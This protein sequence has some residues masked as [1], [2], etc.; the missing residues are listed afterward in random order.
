MNKIKVISCLVLRNGQV[1]SQI[2]KKTAESGFF[3][4]FNSSIIEI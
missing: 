2:Y 4:N 3:A 1:S